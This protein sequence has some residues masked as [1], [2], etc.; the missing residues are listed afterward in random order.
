MAYYN[1]DFFLDGTVEK[2]TQSIFVYGLNQV[3]P[4]GKAIDASNRFFIV[5]VGR[6][7]TTV[8][9]KLVS[10]HKDVFCVNESN[11]P[12]ILMNIFSTTAMI[13]LSGFN[14]IEWKV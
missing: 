12:F 4:E 6:T 5:G 1:G 3:V 11:V 14:L 9:S 10:T 8:L 7:G 13:G 2:N